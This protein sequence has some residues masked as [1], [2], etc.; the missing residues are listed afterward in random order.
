MI[1]RFVQS[2]VERG[3]K[4]STCAT[5]RA[6]LAT[7]AAQFAKKSPLELT[8]DD[9]AAFVRARSAKARPATVRQEVA[10]V[11]V[12]QK[13]CV[14]QGWCQ[15]V[16][17]MGVRTPKP[18]DRLKRAAS[19]VEIGQLIRASE[20]LAE[21]PP[22]GSHADWSWWPAAMALMLHGLRASE[23]LARRAQDVEFH[24]GPEGEVAVVLVRASKSAAGVRAVP[25]TSE[26]AVRVLKDVVRGLK[27]TDALFVSGALATGGV[28]R[29]HRTPFAGV[30]VLRKRLRMTCK[31]AGVD[32]A[33]LCAH[34][35]RHTTVTQA[36]AAGGAPAHSVQ[37]LA[38]H[39]RPSVTEG[40]VHAT[41][42]HAMAASSAVGRVLDAA[43]AG[44]PVLRKV[45]FDG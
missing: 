9:G 32:P 16:T 28:A 34:A 27:P 30:A 41:V 38:G 20:R 3:C 13:W 11:R 29:R 36:L 21:S 33:G 8:K 40:Y 10:A 12:L 6:Q 1:E 42:E 45:N 25:V 39:S 2:R 15:R 35:M 22:L 4:P 5:Y 23:V 17:W 43:R 19:T 44:R 31:E 14:E 37:R 24:A 7:V 18:T 26:W